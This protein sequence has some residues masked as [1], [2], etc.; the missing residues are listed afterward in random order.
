MKKVLSIII[1][2]S[3]SRQIL[4]QKKDDSL[5]VF[6]GEKV[7]VNL[8][9]PFIP[10][11]MD[12]FYLAKYVVIQKVFG[13]YKMDTIEFQVAD[14]YGFPKFAEYKNVLL[15]VEREGGKWYHVKYMYSALYKTVE[16]KWAGM[17]QGRDYEHSYN[18]DTNIRPE[19]MQFKDGPF[20]DINATNY[21]FGASYHPA[22]Y[23]II[24][25]RAYP[26]YG[27]YVEE[28]FLLKRNGFLKYSGYFKGS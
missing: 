12:E 13:E 3:F 22:Y 10:S 9:R 2:L 15:Y 18:K 19:K 28:L 26:T 1:L 23:K 4:G 25:N 27:N 5:F 20:I 14:H 7:S 8:L 17:Y 6:V 24:G 21:G 11:D 16:D